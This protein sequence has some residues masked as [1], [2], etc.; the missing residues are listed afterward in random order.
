MVAINGNNE[1]PEINSESPGYVLKNT[2]NTDIINPAFNDI[3]DP[4]RYNSKQCIQLHLMFISLEIVVELPC[5][6]CFYLVL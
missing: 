5:S 2:S 1:K 6:L 3:H 4:T